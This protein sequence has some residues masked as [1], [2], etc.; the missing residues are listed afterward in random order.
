MASG[1][2]E[3]T[4]LGS[5]IAG[6]QGREGSPV[7]WKAGR[8]IETLIVLQKEANLLAKASNEVLSGVRGRGSYP[9]PTENLS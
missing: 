5:S 9:I 1:M 7:A 3:Q 8:K 4:P 6:P 2:K